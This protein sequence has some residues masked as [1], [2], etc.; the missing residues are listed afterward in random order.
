MQDVN[1]LQEFLTF[2]HEREIETN[3]VVDLKFTVQ[4]LSCLFKKK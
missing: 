4:E 2:K 3:A 1:N